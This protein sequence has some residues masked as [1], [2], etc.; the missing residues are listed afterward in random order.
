[1]DIGLDICR[2]NTNVNMDMETVGVRI[3]DHW[4]TAFVAELNIPVITTSANVT[5][6]NFMTSEEN[7]D[8]QLSSHLDFMVYEGEKHG[9]PSKIIDLT[10]DELIIER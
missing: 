2:I 6:E 3:P 9:S 10:Q 5:K 8:S 4:F 7:L 1:M